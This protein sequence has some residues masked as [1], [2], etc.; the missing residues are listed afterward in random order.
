MP[1]ELLMLF[2]IILF[3]VVI[4]CLH[5]LSTGHLTRYTCYCLYLPLSFFWT[6]WTAFWQLWTCIFRS[7]SLN[8]GGPFSWG[9]GIPRG[10]SGLAVV[11]SRLALLVRFSLSAHEFPSFVPC[12]AYFCASW[13]CNT[14]VILCH[15]LWWLSTCTFLLECILARTFIVRLRY[16]TNA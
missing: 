4:P 6:R 8:R 14:Y 5:D 1:P 9:P 2:P 12:I 7:W 10:A 15:S 11:S 3:I 13:W 16:C